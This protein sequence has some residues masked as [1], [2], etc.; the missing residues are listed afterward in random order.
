MVR[1]GHPIP[2]M[3]LEWHGREACK[4][5]LVFFY[6]FM[7]CVAFSLKHAAISLTMLLWYVV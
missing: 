2:K 1:L 4:H 7:I 5:H 3:S 6:A